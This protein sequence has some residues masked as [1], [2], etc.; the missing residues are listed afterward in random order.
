MDRGLALM[1]R[2]RGQFSTWMQTIQRGIGATDLQ[3]IPTQ[4]REEFIL[5]ATWKG[6]DGERTHEKLFSQEL[7]FGRTY[8]GNPLAL[9]VQRRACDHARDFMREVLGMRGLKT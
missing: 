2:F 4:E 9:A 3:M 5:R 6:P 1:Q 8:G 7:V